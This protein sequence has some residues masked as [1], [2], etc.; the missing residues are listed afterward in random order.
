MPSHR[1]VKFWTVYFVAVI[2]AAVFF[3]VFLFSSNSFSDEKYKKKVRIAFVGDSITG[4]QFP[5]DLKNLLGKKFRTSVDAY[6]SYRKGA[7]SDVVKRLLNVVLIDSVLKGYHYDYVV[8]YSGINDCISGREGNSRDGVAFANTVDM[9][10]MIERNGAI[11]IVIKHH[12]WHAHEFGNNFMC[13]IGYNDLLEEKF[14]T[15]VVLIDTDFL[16]CS[17][18]G[19][20]IPGVLDSQ[21]DAGDGLHLNR[22][23][24]KILAK[25]IYLSV[26]WDVSR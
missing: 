8:I 7:R 18:R 13:S 19:N 26:E 6:V 3:V 5:E 22:L 24:N 16:S 25:E 20:C 9:V 17:N 2:L 4:G 11:P 14:M 12:P 10:G 23:A 21:Y 15:T 1:E